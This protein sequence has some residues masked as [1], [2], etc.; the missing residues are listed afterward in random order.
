MLVICKTSTVYEISTNLEEVANSASF[1]K[2]KKKLL[3]S[4]TDRGPNS[5]VLV[6]KESDFYSSP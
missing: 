5:S 3:G 2:T 4:G 1:F 6:D